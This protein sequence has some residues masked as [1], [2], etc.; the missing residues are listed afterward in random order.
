ML[1]LTKLAIIVVLT[2]ARRFGA[3]PQILAVEFVLLISLATHMLCRPFNC[4]MLQTLQSM[5]LV[6][7]VFTTATLMVPALDGLIAPSVGQPPS[8]TAMWVGLGFTAL[9]NFAVVAVM[10]YAFIFELR[11]F[12]IDTI[13][14]DGK[15][16]LTWADLKAFVKGNAPAWALDSMELVRRR[17]PPPPPPPQQQQQENEEKEE[18]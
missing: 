4:R 17:P 11:R 8:D 13:D 9:L 16:R 18:V 12:A 6:V 15:G 5:S 14:K 3:A 10:L 1:L 2:A 7:L